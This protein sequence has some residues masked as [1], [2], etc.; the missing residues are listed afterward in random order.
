MGSFCRKENA[1]KLSPAQWV[2]ETRRGHTVDMLNA[3]Q[4]SGYGYHKQ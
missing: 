3:M 4:I 1:R 2:P